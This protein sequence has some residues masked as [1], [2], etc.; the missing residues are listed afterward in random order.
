MNYSLSR[1]NI[2]GELDINTPLVVLMEILTASGISCT[3]FED[4]SIRYRLFREASKQRSIETKSDDTLFLRYIVRFV[5]A[6]EKWKPYDIIKAFN[7]LNLFSEVNVTGEPIS[8][9]DK[10]IGELDYGNIVGTTIQKI[11]KLF[12]TVHSLTVGL[13]TRDSIESLNACVLYKA[14]RELGV[15]TT[16][17]TTLE[18][19]SFAIKLSYYSQR[20]LYLALNSLAFNSNVGSIISFIINESNDSI[21]PKDIPKDTFVENND[22]LVYELL[23][24]NWNGIDIIP[25]DTNEEAIINARVLYKVDISNSLT[26]IQAYQ[27]LA[28]Q[29]VDDSGEPYIKYDIETKELE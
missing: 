12:P 23:T 24:K 16:Y 18:E 14:C 11:K 19:M 28:S 2:T 1:L 6:N 21:I 15:N 22:R 13:Q 29:A 4:P 20:E 5:N 8:K 9:L 26:P 3:S 17:D 10:L 27:L 25:A 7:F